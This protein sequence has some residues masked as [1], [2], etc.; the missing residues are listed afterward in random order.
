MFIVVLL[1]IAKNWKQ[2]KCPSNDEWINKLQYIHTMEYYSAIKW[3]KLL[4]ES[5]ADK[6]LRFGTFTAGP[7]SIPGWGRSRR[8]HGLPPKR[9]C[10]I[11]YTEIREDLKNIML[12]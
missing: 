4:R 8:S 12:A 3:N 11:M 5:L 6:W 7:G 2:C 9:E 10:T 1:T